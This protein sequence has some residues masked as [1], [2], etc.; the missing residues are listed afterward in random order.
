MPREHIAID[1]SAAN[2]IAENLFE[3]ITNGGVFIYRN[4]GEGGTV[5]HQEPHRNI[6][7]GNV[8]FHT[9]PVL[10]DT[11][12]WIGSR[13]LTYWF[14]DFC[15]LDAGYDFGSSASDL[16]FAED[17]VAVDNLFVGGGGLNNSDHPNWQANNLSIPLESSGPTLPQPPV[18]V[19]FR[20]L[21]APLLFREGEIWSEYQ[22]RCVEGRLVELQ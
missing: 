2:L 5:R 14:Y 7:A 4:C 10:F 20:E 8:F 13:N 22:V 12:I 17:N 21:E 6:I 19:I 1:G 9:E 11:S 18:C 15:D 3:E 16:D